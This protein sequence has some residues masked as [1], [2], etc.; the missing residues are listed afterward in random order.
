MISARWMVRAYFSNWKSSS[1]YVFYCT[2]NSN[3]IPDPVEAAVSVNRRSNLRRMLGTA[4]FP[5]HVVSMHD[6]LFVRNTYKS[7]R[8]F[9][10]AHVLT[11]LEVWSMWG[12]GHSTAVERRRSGSYIENIFMFHTMCHKPNRK[13]SVFQSL[14][15]FFLLRLLASV[16]V[17]DKYC[18]SAHCRFRFFC[19][20]VCSTYK[21]VLLL[22]RFTSNRKW[23]NKYVS[24]GRIWIYAQTFRIESLTMKS[25]ARSAV[26]RAFV[27]SG[28]CEQ[29]L[30]I[31]CSGWSDSVSSSTFED[32]VFILAEQNKSQSSAQRKL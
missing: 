26:G 29:M 8:R 11:W 9:Y 30:R 6:T 28:F 12:N 2:Y 22:I 18:L 5:M 3:T 15:F 16:T 31:M 19:L 25:F 7:P 1:M 13:H 32:F 14:Q 20:F 23:Q 27:E 17:E 10:I 24:F 4:V 21:F